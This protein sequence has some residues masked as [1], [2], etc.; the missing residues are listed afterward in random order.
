MKILHEF[1]TL[2]LSSKMDTSYF[3]YC[4]VLLPTLSTVL[5]KEAFITTINTNN[6]YYTAV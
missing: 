4:K 6:N 1:V 5:W 2:T 3:S